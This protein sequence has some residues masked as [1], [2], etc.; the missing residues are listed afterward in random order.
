M[1]GYPN[2]LVYFMWKWQVHYMLSCKVGAE[3]LFSRFDKQLFPTSFLIGF[4]EEGNDASPAICFEPEKMEFLNEELKN[5]EDVCEA[6][7]DSDPRKN[8]L[9]TGSGM[10]EEMDMRRHEDNYR[11]ALQDILD[12]SKFFN[13]K[14]HFVSTGVKKGGYRIYI[15]L[16]LN[17]TIYSTFVFLKYIDPEEFLY[18]HLSLI[19]ATI[20]VFLEDCVHRLY[21]PEAG[22]D[23]GPERSTDELLNSAAK[24]FS[25]TIASVGHAGGFHNLYPACNE[26]SLSRYEGQ[27]NEGHLIIC[28]KDHLALELTL[29]LTEPFSIRE[30]RKLRKLLQLST[31]KT[32]V[33]TNSEMVIGLGVIKSTYDS[34]KED[35]FHIYFRGT[36]CFDVMHQS[37]PILL[38]RH[39][40]PEQITQLIV[41]DKFEED[42]RRIFPMATKEQVNEMYKL[43]NAATKISNGCMLVFLDDAKEEASRLKNQSISIKP[44]KL[45]EDTVKI[46]SLIDGA[47]IVDLDGYAHAKG[48]ILDGITGSEGDP[49]RGSRYNSSLTY[50]EFRGWAKPT[51]I[52]VVSEDGMVDIIPK[53]MPKIRHSEIIQF[54]KTL[55]S[56]NSVDNFNDR[57]YY[58]IMEILRRRSFYLTEQE[59]SQIN[60]LNKSLSKLDRQ[61][62]KN[63]WRTFEDFTSN[64]AMNDRYYIE[65][66]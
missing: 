4:K 25:Y 65:E 64:P 49:S 13:D 16:Q 60:E 58:D 18:R 62:G 47:I 46:L 7:S 26:L 48:V 11:K 57:T 31:E 3:S 36:H 53:L 12:R 20:S 39:G 34:T 42:S 51:L 45:D 30:Y 2:Q 24:I 5:I 8:M 63:M 52:V 41:K 61:S 55:E 56:L 59:A 9:Y 32:G 22:R 38:M 15:I 23:R 50:S 66:K 54:I 21:L 44:K 17:K 6:F 10:Q 1:S 35:I 29:E 28:S 37:Q 43:A 33:V 27:E 19:D 14:I 40:K